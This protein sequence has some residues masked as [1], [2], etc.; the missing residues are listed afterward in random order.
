MAVIYA[1]LRES[2]EILGPVFRIE[3]QRRLG[4]VLLRKGVVLFCSRRPQF[5]IWSSCWLDCFASLPVLFYV[6]VE[7]LLSLLFG[8]HV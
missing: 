8:H 4:V 3:R 7:H 5:W 6:W 2:E 1:L